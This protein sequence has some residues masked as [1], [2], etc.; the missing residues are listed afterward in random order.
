MLRTVRSLISVCL[1]LC[2]LANMRAVEVPDGF[3]VETL[4]TNLNAA[5]TFTVTPDGRILI[6]DQTGPLRMW[7]NGGLRP[8][9]VLDLSERL[10]TFW[11]RGLVGVVLHPDFPHTPHLFVTYVAKSPFPHHVISRFTIVGDRADISSE[12]VLL[13][14]DDQTKNEGKLPWGH[15]GGPMCFGTD[16]KLYLGIGEQTARTP[17]QSLESI[18]GKI[19]RINPDGTIPEDNPFFAP[20]TA[21]YRAIW[22]L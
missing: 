13:E 18:L 11:E 22:A 9:P 14:G 16:G 8:A 19:L 1:A 7:K 17:A 6:A 4:A 20:T 3:S 2:V 21:T 10:D 15:Q 12:R 5:T